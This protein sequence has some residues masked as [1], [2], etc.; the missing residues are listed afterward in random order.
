M[1]GTLVRLSGSITMA[2][3]SVFPPSFSRPGWSMFPVTPPP[4]LTPS[5]AHRPLPP[6][7]SALAIGGGCGPGGGLL[8]EFRHLGAGQDLDA[9]L[10]ELLAR[11]CRN[12]GILGGENLRQYLDHGHLD[13]EGAVE[14]GELDADRARTDDQQR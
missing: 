11:E 2:P 13:A 6:L 5:P 1:P 9:L 3:R 10:L 8:A 14:R 7:L 12:L 4:P